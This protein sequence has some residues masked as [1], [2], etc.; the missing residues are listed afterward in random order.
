MK[1]YEAVCFNVVKNLNCAIF[2]SGKL[3]I[4]TKKELKTELIRPNLKSSL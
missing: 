1:F 3:I 2:L 4:L